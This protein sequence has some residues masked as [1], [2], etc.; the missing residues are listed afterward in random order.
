[1]DLELAAQIDI[2]SKATA[3]MMGVGGIPIFDG[4]MPESYDLWDNII[5]RFFKICQT[6]DHLK[7]DLTSTKLNGKVLIWWL[8][9]EKQNPMMN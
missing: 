6:P 3:V 7:R 8:K 1:M 9:Q 4:S 2:D 5:N